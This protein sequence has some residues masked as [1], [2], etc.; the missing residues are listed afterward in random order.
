M[1]E[2]SQ[3]PEESNVC[4]AVK[5]RPLVASEVED[6]CRQC[7]SVTPGCPQVLT[8]QHTFTYDHVFGDGGTAPDQLYSRCIAPLVDGLFKGYNATVFAY[9]QT[10]SGKT[11]TMGSE[12]KPGTRCRG[13]IPDTINDIFNR[14]DAARDRAV[15][16]RVSFVEIHKEEVKDLLLP[17]STGPRPAVT[18]RETP[19][20]DVSL[21]GAVEREVRTREEMAD[22]LEQGTLC[23]STASTSMNNRSSRS[24]AIFT[25]TMEQR[26][27]VQQ[28]A[29]QGEQGADDDGDD[30][31]ETPGEEVEGVEDFLGAK[32][33][34]VD[35]AGSERAKRTKA[36]GARLREG[37][38]INRG[39]LALG[40][41]INAIVDNHKH[42]PYRD[43]KLTRLLQDSLGGNSR[44]V[45]I[46]CV[47]PADSNFEESLNT[48]RYADRA[49]HIRNK[50]VVNR[51]PVAA[52]LAV[53]RNTIA[54]LKSENLSLRR[55]M[56]ATGNEGG[57][58]AMGTSG[59]GNSALES[60]VDRLTQENNSLES[61]NLR[62]K[63][64]ME[65]LRR[66]L[67]VVADKWHTAQAQCDLLKLNQ[68]A[69]KGRQDSAGGS[70]SELPLPGLD[71][72][73]GYVARIAELE[74]E[75][76]SMKSLAAHMPFTR[77]R[78]NGAEHPRTP[79]GASTP[80]DMDSPSP[81]PSSMLD[82][83][84]GLDGAADDG[85]A[86]DDA[87]QHNELAAEEEYF[88]AELAAHTLNQEKMKKEVALL[89][90]QLEAKERK[91]VEL[92]KNTG[93]VPALK[94]H[95]DRVL[96]DLEAQRDTLVAERK[97][98]M[99]KLAAAS[100]A[101]EEER[102]RLEATYMERIHQ[103]D[104]R[105]KEL[106]RKE[107]DFIAMQ[108]LKQRTEDAHRR[109]SADILR[110]K[111]QKVAVQKQLEAN[112]KQFQ[113]W[114]HE[115]EREM[116]QLRKQSRKDRAQIQ[117]LQA[118][119]AK[120]SAVLQRKISD[121][122]AA[123]KRIKELEEEK[124]RK[125]ASSSV[126]S[127]QQAAAAVAAQQA[128]GGNIEIQPNAQAPL[129]RTDKDR[130]DWLQRELDLCNMACEFRKVI[131]GELAQRAEATKRLK[132][133]EKRLTILDQMQPASPLFMA[134]CGNVAL[135]FSPA[136]SSAG[137]LGPAA[138]VGPEAR[139]K[140][141]AKKKELE[142]KVA[143]HNDQITEMQH[144]WERQK[145]EEESR[146][147]GAL[148][149]RR[150]AGLRNVAECREVL[151]ILF[152]MSVESK[153]LGAEL[154]VDMVRYQEEVDVLRV[155][156][157]GAQKKCAQY[158]KLAMALQA[159]AARVAS[160]PH[161]S[162]VSTQDETD[163]QVDAV[164]EELHV[165]RNNTPPAASG[166]PS[167][168]AGGDGEAVTSVHRLSV[169][170]PRSQADDVEMQDAGS[171]DTPKTS[172]DGPAKALEFLSP[173]PAGARLR[174]VA[175][176]TPGGSAQRYSP[177]RDR[178]SDDS[179]GQA[180]NGKGR[181]EAGSGAAR[182]QRRNASGS[183]DYCVMEVDS[184]S[185]TEAVFGG[186]KKAVQEAVGHMRDGSADDDDVDQEDDEESSE[187]GYSDEE[188]DEE[189]D[190]DIEWDPK[191]ATPALRGRAARCSRRFSSIPVAGVSSK[192]SSRRPSPA[193]NSSSD[194][195]VSDEDSAANTRR[196]KG[197][198][199]RRPAAS[200]RNSSA[201]AALEA[202]VLDDINLKHLAA[203][204][205]TRH[206][207]LTVQLLKDALKGKAIDGQKW[208][209]R[210]QKRNKTRAE[211]IQDYR[212]M[213][214]LD[215]LPSQPQSA[216]HSPDADVKAAGA[217]GRGDPRRGREGAN[218]W[219]DSSVGGAG[220]AELPLADS[221]ARE[222]AEEPQGFTFSP[223]LPA[224]PV[225]AAS[226]PPVVPPI[227]LV[228]RSPS[229]SQATSARR[230]AA[231]SPGPGALGPWARSSLA[232]TLSARQPTTWASSL[233]SS[234]S[235][236]QTNAGAEGVPAEPGLVLV[237]SN[238]GS[239]TSL[240]SRGAAGTAPQAAAAADAAGG[241]GAASSRR[242]TVL[243]APPSSQAAAGGASLPDAFP[244]R[245]AVLASSPNQSPSARMLRPPVPMGAAAASP[246]SNMSSPTPRVGARTGRM[247]SPGMSPESRDR[248][249]GYHGGENMQPDATTPRGTPGSA[250]GEGKGTPLTNLYKQK[251][252]AS[253]ERTAALRVSMHKNWE[254]QDPRSGGGVPGS[255][256]LRSSMNG[257]VGTTGTVTSSIDGP[258]RGGPL[259]DSTGAGLGVSKAQAK[260]GIWR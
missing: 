27:Q 238:S 22:V 208:Q 90:R 54:Q 154:T 243:G 25:I 240:S 82:D 188:D 205:Q 96:A 124:R 217:G 212:R 185:M 45:M 153:S 26:R 200:R 147:G 253:R 206:Q 167:R 246:R 187:E 37:I 226:G 42:V 159:A 137:A 89:Q 122:T 35:L 259:R 173:V 10:G 218:G 104:D 192:H 73:K 162:M 183:D 15:T 236:P 94:Q 145:A 80:G 176:E 179:D 223:H 134:G 235:L 152:R 241:A 116:G 16:V 184:D 255:G 17:A 68:A 3:A 85:D 108:K 177:E 207:K 141:L 258:L 139:E 66:E 215:K 62:L 69:A 227:A 46:A 13:V 247:Y 143:L 202:P 39:L 34:L 95:Y 56:A 180:Q 12:Y 168:S 105:L 75:V 91:M 36:E 194:D 157:D 71:I 190:G 146:G 58:D 221:S 234:C 103:Y 77:R 256:N 49:R 233:R 1:A 33:H 225:I 113:A 189:S 72:V 43:S 155:Q 148:D 169:V 6:G 220:S 216:A 254:Q 74:A 196:G 251:A 244:Y 63:M 88:M 86:D 52:Q 44:T 204:A 248:A 171:P 149:V 165:V 250:S 99:E 131:D 93:S 4:V 197:S 222:P 87:N 130:R 199:T 170:T 121:A 23:R 114:R 178:D 60:L 163:K 230:P 172:Q 32:M 210:V 252:L 198:G 257:P 79:G 140:L 126:T 18:I 65:D 29:A 209:G 38:H 59:L 166:A 64:E 182:E 119:A 186:S 2:L 164:L 191:N 133:L 231:A 132:E 219:S 92:M 70:D 245:N 161:H 41:V 20:G 84:H 123:R 48:L 50:P 11:F 107:R 78:A 125:T 97:A 142:E 193:G 57:V 195:F 83:A 174:L 31:D 156:L 111:Q 55:A 127:Q 100:A 76:M 110:L 136:A 117:H 135:P 213:L 67:S 98:L 61:D 118:M 175:F 120:Q 181:Q 203:G 53:L 242:P 47:S 101:S 249:F 30:D 260:P 19:N 160:A 232:Q 40:N 138:A 151:R 224:A 115:R 239:N 7:V 144:N 158:R 214:G 28:T 211:L 102:K 14:I 81:G 21:Y 150:W 228:A 8:G 51:D 106:R 5:I 9:G 201:D 128:M 237:R 129:L 109:L 229:P 24:H 112:A